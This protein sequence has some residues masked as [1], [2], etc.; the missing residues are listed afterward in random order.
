MSIAEKI[1]NRSTSFLVN[2]FHIEEIERVVHE[3]VIYTV[4]KYD[5]LGARINYYI[6]FTND[7]SETSVIGTLKAKAA[8][9]NFTAVIVSDTLNNIAECSCYSEHKFFDLLGRYWVR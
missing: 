8:R 4:Y 7:S 5:K 6:L 1:L 2:G 9:N 3:N